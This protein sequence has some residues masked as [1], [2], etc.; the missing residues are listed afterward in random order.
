[1]YGSSTSRSTCQQDPEFVRLWVWVRDRGRTSTDPYLSQETLLH[2]GTR[3]EERKVGQRSTHCLLTP[4]TSAS[5]PFDPHVCAPYVTDDGERL[6]WV[7][8]Y[9]RFRTRP[10]AGLR[11]AG[12]EAHGTGRVTSDPRTRVH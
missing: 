4:R 5:T 6:P 8:Q 7:F 9:G 3:V 1:M 10:L 2:G 11:A 12:T